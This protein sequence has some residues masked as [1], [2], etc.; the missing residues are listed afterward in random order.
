MVEWDTG[1]TTTEPLSLISKTDPITCAI[2]AKQNN[3][4]HTPGWQ[5]LK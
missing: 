3:L 1:E 4:L 2:Y 5:Y